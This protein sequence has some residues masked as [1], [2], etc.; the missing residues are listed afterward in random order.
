MR[1]A[2]PRIVAVL[3]LS[4]FLVIG[5]RKNQNQFV[6]QSS[7][8]HVDLV[9]SMEAVTIA[10][11]ITND[12]MFDLTKPDAT[13][14]I[15]NGITIRDFN[16]NPS[17]YI[18]SFVSNG[19]VVI[20]ADRNMNP[21]LAYSTES[22]LK[23]GKVSSGLMNWLQKTNEAV[24]IVRKGKYDNAKSAV[25][26]WSFIDRRLQNSTGI[27]HRPPPDENPCDRITHTLQN[28]LLPVTWGQGCTYNAQCPT[29]ADGPCGFAWTGCVATAT[30]QVMRYWQRPTTFNWAIMPAATGN[31][32]VARL[33]RDIGDGV[34]M[35]WSGT[36]SGAYH[37]NIDDVL[38]NR[39]GYRISNDVGYNT[40]KV[41][42]DISLQHP[43]ILSGY[44]GTYTTG[45]WIFER[46][47]YIDGHEWVCDGSE[48]Y[49]NPCMSVIYLHMNWGWHETW[50]ADD[51]NGWFR[52]F[53]WA[54]PGT[55]LNFQY[56]KRAI[57]DIIP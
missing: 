12:N 47:H 10:S 20:A 30:A 43:V 16:N 18:F 54:I 13:K 51:H 29:A 57:V 50:V 14:E 46:T 35:S 55:D 22:K 8:Y 56:Y 23:G 9:D 1:K 38:K 40:S 44:N 27:T 49:T 2:P 31:A 52:D 53:S 21:I 7:P 48:I 41:L 37:E 45:W 25:S 36:G 17:F 6:I 33:M 39:Y 19:F 42:G 15:E 28:P 5:C 3:M 32:E 4:L 34:G 11:R 24:E 26:E